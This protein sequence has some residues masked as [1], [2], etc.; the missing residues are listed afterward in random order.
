MKLL[1]P[2][3]VYTRGA[4]LWVVGKDNLMVYE[5]EDV[6]DAF[7][8]RYDVMQKTIILLNLQLEIYKPEVWQL[9]ESSMAI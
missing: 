3:A 5:Q 9:V 6:V 2:Q 8:M 1:H 7:V 4:L